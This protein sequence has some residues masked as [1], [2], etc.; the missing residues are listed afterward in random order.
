M[1]LGIV[2]LVSMVFGITV[3]VKSRKQGK[4]LSSTHND[5]FNYHARVI[6]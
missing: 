6:K 5:N 1:V 4:Y 2:V 3:V